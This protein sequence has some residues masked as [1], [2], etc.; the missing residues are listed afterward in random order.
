MRDL[1]RNPSGTL[2]KDGEELVVSKNGMPSYHITPINSVNFMASS[3]SPSGVLRNETLNMSKQ[4]SGEVTI[5]EHK[6]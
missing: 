5:H 2:P 1:L 6:K 3:L 4:P